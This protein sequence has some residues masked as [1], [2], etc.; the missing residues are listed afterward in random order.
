MIKCEVNVCAVITRNASVMEKDRQEF[1]VF[2]IKVPIVDR[3][4]EK[5]NLEIS[6]SNDGGKGV[7][8][9]FTTGCRVVIKG[10]LSVRKK[11][12]KT[13][14]NLRSIGNA[15]IAPSTAEDNIEGK[16]E[17]IGKIGK[18][19]VSTKTD[20]NDNP[21]KTFSAFSTD[22]DGDNAEFTWVS[23]MYFE[24]KQDEAFLAAGKYVHVNGTLQFGVYKEEVSLQCV[25]GEISEYVFPDDK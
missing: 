21:F 3:N 19:G 15:E 18:N 6:V 17:F 25:V 12:G 11:N 7:A 9:S 1:F 24:P 5:K 4:G 23:F 2:N 20:K 22:K 14:Y 16:M 13:F 10:I 8:A